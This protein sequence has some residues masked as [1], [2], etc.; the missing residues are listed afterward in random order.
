MKSDKA[1]FPFLKVLNPPD[2]RKGLVVVFIIIQNIK[3]P[4]FKNI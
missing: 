1:P 2:D 3:N 4:D